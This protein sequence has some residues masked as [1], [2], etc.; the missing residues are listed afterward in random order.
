MVTSVDSYI[1]LVFDIDD[2]MYDLMAPFKKSHDHLFAG[3]VNADTT[4]LFKKSR[5]YS[6][7]ILEREK[8]GEIPSTDSFHERL[9]MTYQDVGLKITR[10]ESALF[11]TEYRYYQTKIEMFDFMRDVLDYCKEARLP[12]AVLT[13]GSYKGQWKKAEALNLQSWFSPEQIFISGEIGYHK[14]DVRAFQAVSERMHFLPEQTWYVGD[15][16][17][18]D[19]IGAS[20]A[21]WHTIWLNHR[22]R[23]CPEENCI[24]DKEIHEGIFLLPLIKTLL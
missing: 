2:T 14:P 1:Y 23:A 18:S 15:T 9:R 11:E 3:R 7:I 13:N 12:I 24:A 21:G 16:Y 6:D 20:Q 10:E 5:I 4:E 8:N 17:E 22:M 19:I